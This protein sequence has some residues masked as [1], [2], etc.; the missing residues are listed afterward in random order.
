MNSKELR[1]GNHIYIDNKE[2]AITATDLLTMSQ[3]ERFLLEK[4]VINPIFLSESLLF[5]LGFKVEFE[6][7]PNRVYSHGNFLLC[8]NANNTFNFYV[9]QQSTG[10]AVAYLHQLQNLYFLMTGSELIQ[11]DQPSGNDAVV[12]VEDKET[13]AKKSSIRGLLGF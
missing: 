3:N 6:V 13:L 1:I 9:G 5:R 4:Q 8:S 2:T 7:S 12:K 11:E 10:K